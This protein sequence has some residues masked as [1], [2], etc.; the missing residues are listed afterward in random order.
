MKEKKSMIF[1]PGAGTSKDVKGSESASVASGAVIIG[2]GYQASSEVFRMIVPVFHHVR[3]FRRLSPTS[4]LSRKQKFPSLSLK[5][6]FAL[7]RLLPILSILPILL[8]RQS[9][10]DFFCL[11]YVHYLVGLPASFVQRMARIKRALLRLH[12]KVTRKPKRQFEE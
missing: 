8:L 5:I 9:M 6:S 10:H 4:P 2:L 1:S 12:E 3:L 7:P 11:V